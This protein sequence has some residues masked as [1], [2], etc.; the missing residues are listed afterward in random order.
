MEEEEMIRI[1]AESTEP[2]FKE[3]FIN[4]ALAGWNACVV[5]IL[6]AIKDVHNCKTVKKIIKEKYKDRNVSKTE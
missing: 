1:I 3:Q 5:S 6:S 4:G 2:L